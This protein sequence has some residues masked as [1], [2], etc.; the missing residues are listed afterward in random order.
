MSSAPRRSVLLASIGAA[1]SK[2]EEAPRCVGH[3]VG[4]Q[5]VMTD[6]Y[7]LSFHQGM[8][9]G[10]TTAVMIFPQASGGGGGGG[11]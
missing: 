8:K 11:S 4:F 2:D 9:S 3:G 6:E 7:V 1:L 10:R 5:P